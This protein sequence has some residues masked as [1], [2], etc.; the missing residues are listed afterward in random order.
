MGRLA[1][2][3]AERVVSAV[4]VLVVVTIVIFSV[5]H[6]IPGDPAQLMA[7]PHATDQEIAAMR[8]RMGLDRPLLRQYV[9]YVSRLARG[10]LGTSI[11]T[12]RPVFDEIVV[13]LPAT[14]ELMVPALLISAG[15]G[16]FLGVLAAVFRD[17]YFDYFVRFASTISQSI[18]T[19][20]LSLV[21]VVLFYG[22]LG[23]LPASGRLDANLT[24]PPHVSGFYLLDSALVGNW[25]VF[26]SAFAHLTLPVATLVLSNV[27]TFLR[28][29][30]A[31]MA[32]ILLEDYIRTAWASG[33]SWSAVILR[34]ALRNAL[35]PFVT[36][37]GIQLASLLFGSVVIESVFAWP[38]LGTHVLNAIFDL[39]FPVIVGFAAL[40]S[41]AY[42]GINLMIDISYTL[43]D[44][45]VDIHN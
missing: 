14:L 31:S 22:H 23:I 25:R 9:D 3:V 8:H 40:V 37:L 21:L 10:D 11:V 17:S 35:F 42:V 4:V 43:L 38:G 18:P 6:L 45:R 5:S 30:R 7:G 34:H 33:F 20:W 12:R 28:L 1:R 41:L 16:T 36:V 44:P 29:V 24:S 26:R 2:L 13:R 15:L 19:F 39:D 32:E 27:G